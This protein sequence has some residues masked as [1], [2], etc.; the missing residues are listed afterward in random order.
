[1][2]QVGGLIELGCVAAQR[3]QRE[4]FFTWRFKV[5]KNRSHGVCKSIL[6]VLLVS[7]ACRNRP[8]AV[9]LATSPRKSP[10]P[11]HTSLVPRPSTRAP[12]ISDG[13]R[14]E[15]LGTRLGAYSARSARLA[16]KSWLVQSTSEITVSV[17]KCIER[18]QLQTSLLPA[19]NVEV[20]ST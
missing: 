5:V 8:M 4:F 3:A 1:M 7:R 9:D 16:V 6:E 18:I 10:C 17:N 12:S 11:A 20:Q 19:G 13:A 15:G 2:K 14:V